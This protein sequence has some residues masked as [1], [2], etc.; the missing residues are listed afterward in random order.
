MKTFK[1][2]FNEKELS[3]LRKVLGYRVLHLRMDELSS[4]RVGLSAKSI[5]K[6]LLLT[7]SLLSK[8]S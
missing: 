8:L 4:L 1:L 7:D 6:E 3:I 2:E 5:R